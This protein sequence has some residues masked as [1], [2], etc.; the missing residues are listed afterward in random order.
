MTEKILAWLEKHGLARFIRIT[1][2][3]NNA[4]MLDNPA[5]AEKVPGV[6]IGRAGE[7]FIVTPFESALDLMNSIRPSCAIRKALRGRVAHAPNETRTAVR[8]SIC[9]RGKAYMKSETIEY[10]DGDLMLEGFV[11][12]DD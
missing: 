4:A 3:V 2:D 11:A 6:S 1:K 7:D 10:R 8:R 12:F 5:A 9:D